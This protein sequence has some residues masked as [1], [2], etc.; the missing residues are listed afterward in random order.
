MLDHDSGRTP[1]TR[2]VRCTNSMIVIFWSSCSCLPN[3]LLASINRVH[4]MLL[5]IMKHFL[6]FPS[7]HYCCIHSIFCCKTTRYRLNQTILMMRSALTPT[8][9]AILVVITILIS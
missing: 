2:I 9:I 4:N 1:I 7:R 6:G 8:V 5:L 3:L